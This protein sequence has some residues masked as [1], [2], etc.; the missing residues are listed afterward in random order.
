MTVLVTGA[1]GFIGTHLVRKLVADGYTV[2][3]LVRPSSQVSALESI[4]VERV[5][6]DLSDRAAM[7]QAV[8]DC[9]TV[10]HLAVLRPR[11]YADRHQVRATN[12]TGTENVMAAALKAGV[13]RLVHVSSVGVY[14]LVTRS[15]VDETTL[16]NPNSLRRETKWLGEQVAQSYVEKHGLPVVIA[17]LPG[18]LGAGAP[19]WLPLFRGIA[20]Q[21]FRMVGT[22]ET[23]EHLGYVS[24]IVDGLM[25]CA[26]TPGIV[27]QTYL[28]AS[29]TPIKVNEFVSL[30]AQEFGV[31]DVIPQKP[32]APYRLVNW[33]TD[34]VYQTIGYEFPIRK[35]IELF[36][37]NRV[38]DISKAKRELGYRPQVSIQD[39]IHHTANWYRSQQQIKQ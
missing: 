28:L 23:Y 4:G 5:Y 17:R 9:R 8:R 10:Y 34:V 12:I 14:G 30:I 16:P 11:R 20:A 26:E 15:P 7:E 25:L 35:E 13:A 2:R 21:R 19:N 31:Q 3:A 33:A 6:G 1:T 39:A 18:V 24:D 22:G 37:A 38:L 27:G 32:I 29:E 36:L